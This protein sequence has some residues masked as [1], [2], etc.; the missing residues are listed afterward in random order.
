M[1][2]VIFMLLMLYAFP[3]HAQDMQFLLHDYS[4]IGLTF[5][6]PA[7][8]EH[9]GLTV[10]TKAGFIKQFGWVYDKPDADDIWNAVGGFSSFP[11]DSSAAPTEQ[12][13][14]MHKMTV[15]V[16]RAHTLYRRWLCLHRRNGVFEARP[17]INEQFTLVEKDN[18]RPFDL[19]PNLSDAN[20]V[21]YRYYAGQT[22]LP[23]QGHVF[24]FVHQEKCYE[25]R[26]ES[27][28]A[29]PNKSTRVHERILNSLERR[30]F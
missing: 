30:S 23:T 11:V 15:F 17:L 26:L 20:G 5:M 6:V 1:R 22:R 16:S 14:E 29:N 21:S 9:D 19:P 10:T 18:I 28:A 8:W 4:P 27:T 25:L 7:N 3:L 24:T 12:A 2:K 13:F